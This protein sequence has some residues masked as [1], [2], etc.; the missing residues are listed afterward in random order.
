MEK[1]FISTSILEQLP[2]YILADYQT[3]ARFLQAYFEWLE[4]DTSVVGKLDRFKD[5]RDIDNTLIEFVKHFESEYLFNI[6]K[7]L[8]S[9]NGVSVN[10][11]SLIKHIK[12]F[13]QT[14]GTENSFKLLFRILFNEDVEFYYPKSDMLYVSDGK[15]SFDEILRCT[16][17]NDTFSFIGK[18]IYGV[19]SGAS[20]A[21]ENIFNIQ[22]DQELV[23]ELYISGIIGT[24][25]PGEQI[26]ITI[27]DVD[28]FETLFNMVSKINVIVPG[29]GYKV[30]DPII[31]IGSNSGAIA[32]EATVEKVKGRISDNIAVIDGGFGYNYPPTVQI[33]GTGF[34]A[35][36]EAKLSPT[37]LLKIELINSGSGFDILNPPS[38]EFIPNIISLELMDISDIF[39]VGEI[40]IG[41]TTNRS[42]IVKRFYF[43]SGKYYVDLESCS[44]V[45]QIDENIEGQTS[46]STAKITDMTPSGA[47]AIAVVANN[48][49]I[50]RIDIL[51]SGQGFVDIPRVVVRNQDDSIN[52][53]VVARAYLNPTTVSQ[54]ILLNGGRDYTSEGN[55]FVKFSGGFLDEGRD[56]VALAEIE[57]GIVNVLINNPGIRYDVVPSYSLS[58]ASGTGAQLS[59]E[60]G[61]KY[62]NQ[63]RWLNTDSFISSDKFIQDSFYYQVFSYVLK[64]TQSINSYRDVVKNI[65]HP[66]GL[67]LFGTTILTSFFQLGPTYSSLEGEKFRYLPRE[68]TTISYP[69]PNNTYW[70]TYANTQIF[71]WLGTII[72]D[73]T[74]NP[75]SRT[76]WIPDVFVNVFNPTFDVPTTGMLV[77]YNFIEG[78]NPQLLYDISDNPKYN[79]ILGNTILQDIN[80]PEWV[81]TGLRFDGHFVNCTTIPVNQLEKTII[82]VAKIERFDRPAS[83]VGCLDNDNL[84]FVSGYSINVNTNKSIK[85][86]TQKR[87]LS[88]PGTFKIEYDTAPNSISETSWFM[89]ALRY[90]DNR[91]IVNFNNEP[92]VFVDFPVNVVSRG[93]LN[94]SKGFYYGNQGY[95]PPLSEG[96]FY[97]SSF[98]GKTL[99]GAGSEVSITFIPINSLF[100]ESLFNEVFFDGNVEQQI[101][102]VQPVI[103]QPLLNGIIAYSYIYNRLITD[104]ETEAIYVSLRTSLNS[105][106]VF[107][108]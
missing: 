57:G 105:R 78:V 75:K 101:T 42:G 6:P 97:G 96:S 108:P 15:W 52:N 3:F 39:Q 87:V 19:T 107:L 67:M 106:G 85:F 25:L 79:G 44:G 46:N 4:L 68:K 64:S 2:R 90:K 13:N 24:F 80:D 104:E 38:I 22:I 35:K 40:V 95:T 84:N 10:K 63:G 81:S 93:I 1:Q 98:Y 12:Q 11:A 91:M 69:F 30:G 102:F 70:N 34:D 92:S 86:V 65:L 43:E 36:A 89:V 49:T 54:I 60:I 53:S 103:G 77:E 20:A 58:Y 55:I 82:V 73:I 27:D 33:I 74:L 76:N 59:F 88:P 94:N 21:V 48:T 50:E 37:G 83:I 16:T 7:N 41:Q 51:N 62:K 56:A 66:A 72:G 29:I 31:I 99:Y 47:I 18:R 61:P 9:E 14:R 26:R 71:P 5:F 100:N 45:F 28:Y 32:A 23:S 17:N 8:Y